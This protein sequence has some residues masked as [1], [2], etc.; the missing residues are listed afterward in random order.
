MLRH[1]ALSL[2]VFSAAV[3]A[4]TAPATPP[5]PL[6]PGAACKLDPY[7]Q[8]DFW[9]G[10]WEVTEHGQPAGRSRIEPILEHCAIA[11]HWSDATGADGK[12][13]NAFDPDTKQWQQFWVS[14]R[15]TTLLL[16]GGMQGKS[17]VLEGEH[18]PGGKA[19]RERITWTPNADGSVRQLWEQ[20]SDGGKSWSAVFDGLYRRS[21]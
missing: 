19:R 7:H 1:A 6:A 15:G 21:K 13:Y 9:I 17:M 20:S 3:G 18:A 10:E 11:E 14:A 8:F 2:L 5:A 12:S 16:R 4:E